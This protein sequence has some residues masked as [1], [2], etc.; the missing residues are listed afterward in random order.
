MGSRSKSMSSWRRSPSYE[1]LQEFV[2]PS[3]R[4]GGVASVEGVE[5]GSSL[6]RLRR[7]SHQSLVILRRGGGEGEGLLSPNRRRR[8]TLSMSNSAYSV[9]S[10]GQ[11]YASV[12]GED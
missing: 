1:K 12:T 6:E 10:G 2:L 9:E 5:A 3:V 8:Q 11:S 4:E 7:P